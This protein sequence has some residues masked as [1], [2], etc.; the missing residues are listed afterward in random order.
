MCKRST[1]VIPGLLRKINRYE[2]EL[3]KEKEFDR[4]DGDVKG[5]KKNENWRQ[6]EVETKKVKL[7][8]MIIIVGL[9]YLVVVK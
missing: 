4:S 6:I 3:G 9:L 1:E 2:V 8:L 5:C 7:M